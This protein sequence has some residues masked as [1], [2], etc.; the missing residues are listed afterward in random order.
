MGHWLAPAGSA[1]VPG[2]VKRFDARFW[3]VDFPRPMMASVVTTGPNALRVECVFYKADDLAGLIWEAQDRRDHP[4]LAYETARDFRR[5]RLSFRWRSGGVVPLDAVHGPTLTIEGRD[6]SGAARSW[7]V[8]LWNYA[9]G[10]N[11]D[12]LVELDFGTCAGGW[13]ADDPVWAGDVDR[14]FISLVA[15]GYSGGAGRHRLRRL[16]FGAG[17]RRCDR[18]GAS[19]AH[20]HR[21]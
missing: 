21:L 3:T 20:R 6:A 10:T 14:M 9:Q 15:P 16:R 7:F 4:L 1:K 17:D 19:A 11:E 13:E 2:T 8:R 18:A 5:C 12:A